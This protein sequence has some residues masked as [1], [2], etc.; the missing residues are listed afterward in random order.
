MTAPV[1]ARRSRG[2]LVAYLA[3]RAVQMELGSWQSL[4]RF[5]FRRPRVP[6]GATGFPYHRSVLAVHLTITAVSVLE[7][8]AVD[9]LVQHWPTVRIPLLVIGVWGVAWM[10]GMLA[11]MITRPHAVG[12]EGIRARYTT[13]VDVALPWEAIDA[14]VR[15]TRIR[16]DK[17]PRLP[18]GADELELWM[19]E[20]TNVDVLLARPVHVHLPEGTATV[21]RI[22]LFADDPAAFLAAVRTH[23]ERSPAT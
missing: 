23:V 11:A 18:P 22:G 9:V 3:G 19:Q 5:A 15:R 2:R 17:A 8:V 21:R 13:D 10:L 20:R 16:Q 1:P 14:V 7:L 12:P 6:V 4:Y